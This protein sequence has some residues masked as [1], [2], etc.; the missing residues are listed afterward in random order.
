MRWYALSALGQVALCS[1][2]G[3]LFKKR[4][5]I[6]GRGSIHGKRKINS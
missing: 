5:V 2:F 3:D 4:I 1:G 6:H